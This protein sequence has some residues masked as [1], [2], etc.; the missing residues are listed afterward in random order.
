MY[1][2]RDDSDRKGSTF[3]HFFKLSYRFTIQK[4]PSTYFLPMGP[5]FTYDILAYASVVPTVSCANFSDNISSNSDSRFFCLCLCTAKTTTITI[6]TIN[7]GKSHAHSPNT[8]C[9]N[10]LLNIL[11]SSFFYSLCYTFFI[12]IFL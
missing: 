10:K 11:H 6:S 2:L 9:E 8:L 1:I 7:A 5:Y 4:V 12:F 3:F